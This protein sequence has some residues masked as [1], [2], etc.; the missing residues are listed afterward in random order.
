MA[1]LTAPFVYKNDEK[2]I[3]YGPV[4]IPD[5]PDTDDDVVTAEQIENVAHGFVEQYGNIDIQHSLN[6]V[7]RLVESYILPVDLEVDGDNI[8]PKGSWL[9][10]VRVT[11]DEAWQSVKSGEL[12]GFSIM[13]IHNQAIKSTEKNDE[14]SKRVTLADLDEMGGWI[15]NAVSLVDEPAVPKAKFL[16]IKSSKDSDSNSNDDIDIAKKAIDGSLEHRKMLI[17][18]E[19]SATFSDNDSYVFIHATMDD[20]VIFE[21]DDAEG[22]VQTFQ[23]GYQIQDG[24]EIAFAGEPKE[25][26]IEEKVVSA[27]MKNLLGSE[28]EEPPAD[29]FMSKL[30]QKLGFSGKTSQDKT[31]KDEGGSELEKDEIVELIDEKI[32]PVES[33]V[34]EIL[35][36]LQTDGDEDE[37]DEDEED[38]TEKSKGGEAD[39]SGDEDD[40]E[41]KST[42]KSKDDDSDDEDYEEKYKQ[43]LKELE[44]RKNVPFSNRLVGQDGAEKSKDDE[45]TN[46]R[47]AFGYKS[48]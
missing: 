48:K 6:N 30:M 31:E 17:D 27:K 7:G 39:E 19:L 11:N 43:A 9:M 13:A 16:A 46:N 36:I 15:V 8:V 5:E 44:N 41:D 18:Q 4:L 38:E 25:V 29:G 21:V 40:S 37:K 28:E 45:E 12:G 10:G 35:E 33:K 47:N 2:R 23:V 34:N 32:E 42:G 3:V 22:N 20:S 1:E 14:E 26:R 24:G